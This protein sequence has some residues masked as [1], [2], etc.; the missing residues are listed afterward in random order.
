MNCTELLQHYGTK[1]A[2]ARACGVTDQHVHGWFQRNTVPLPHQMKLEVDSGGG[3][4]ADVSDEY[5]QLLAGGGGGLT[6]KI[7]GPVEEG[8][9][10]AP[11]E[12]GSGA[13]DGAD[14]IGVA[15]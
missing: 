5:R 3:L 10:P 12:V 7:P 11:S 9:R 15:A 4:R 6:S 8:D 1:A 14:Q 2:I 13:A